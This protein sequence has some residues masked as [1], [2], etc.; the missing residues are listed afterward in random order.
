MFE[1]SINAKGGFIKKLETKAK[2]TIEYYDSMYNEDIIIGYNSKQ[3]RDLDYKN[4]KNYD[5]N[6]FSINN[7]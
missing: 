5:G 4:I 1:N 3:E 7:N 6:Y 2:F